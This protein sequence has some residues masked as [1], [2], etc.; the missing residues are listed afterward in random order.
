MRGSRAAAPGQFTV[1][2]AL[3]ECVIP[4]PLPVN[5]SVK[6]P[7][8]VLRLVLTVSVDVAVDEVM[9][10]GLGLKV[11]VECAGRP[12]TLKLT[13]L[14]KPFTAV[15]VTVSRPLVPRETLK[16]GAATEKSGC[17]ANGVALA[18]VELEDSPRE[19]TALTT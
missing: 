13:G 8:G 11:A 6:F 2:V 19:F 12:L 3:V 15:M 16:A 5:V 1:K 18:W 14:L 17:G 9:L 10:T 7:F 4:P